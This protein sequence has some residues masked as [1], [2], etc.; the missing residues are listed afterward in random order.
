MASISRGRKLRERDRMGSEGRKAVGY[1]HGYDAQVFYLGLALDDGA[2]FGRG[3][4][5][6][7]RKAIPEGGCGV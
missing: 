1:V 4:R 6:A 2:S 5:R 7:L 3:V